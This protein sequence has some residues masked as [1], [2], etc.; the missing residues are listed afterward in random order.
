[1]AQLG[2]R[3]IELKRSWEKRLV[4]QGVR[5]RWNPMELFSD[6]ETIFCR[7]RKECGGSVA[8]RS[9]LSKETVTPSFFMVNPVKE[10][11][12]MILRNLWII[13]V[14]GGRDTFIVRG[15]W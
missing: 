3:L 5:R 8:K 15:F 9:G 7:W 10:G 11:A 14:I 6:K 4:G 13:W 12:T 2:R 1:M